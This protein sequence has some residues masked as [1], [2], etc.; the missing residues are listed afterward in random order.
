MSSVKTAARDSVSRETVA[1]DFGARAFQA[2]SLYQGSAGLGK[3]TWKQ[4]GE[5]VADL[6]VDTDP[7][8][9]STVGKW[10]KGGSLPDAHVIL[11]LGRLFGVSPGWLAFG[12][13]KPGFASLS[14][15]DEADIMRRAASAAQQ[16]RAAQGAANTAKQA[17]PETPRPKRKRG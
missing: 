5:W 12:E 10:M 9:Q 7:F 14:P 8:D 15:D 1:S 13:G 2:F 3:V 11:A 16:A 4:V 17:Q 6:I